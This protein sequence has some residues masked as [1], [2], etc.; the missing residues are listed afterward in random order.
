MQAFVSDRSDSNGVPSNPRSPV[1]P[2]L[3]QDAGAARLER[4]RGDGASYRAMV[5]DVRLADLLAGLSLISDHELG[6]P[7]DDAVRSCLV[8]TGLARTLESPRPRGRGCV[9][10]LAAPARR[11]H[12]IRARDLPR[13]GRRS[14]GEPGGAENELRPTERARHGVPADASPRRR[15]LGASAGRRTVPHAGGQGS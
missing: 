3:A 15:R 13:M 7:P 9:L 10:R 11:L 1:A 12:G 2:P 5:N 6:L 8:G 4:G 14:S